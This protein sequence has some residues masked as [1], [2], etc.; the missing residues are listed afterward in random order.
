MIGYIILGLS[1]VSV[2]SFILIYNRFAKLRAEIDAAWSEIDI[3]LLRRH[4]LIPNLVEAVKAYMAHEK[5]TLTQ[6]I[7]ARGAAAGAKSVG[8]KMKAANGLTAALGRFMMV[9]ERYPD[10]KADKNVSELTEELTTTENRIAFSRTHY[11]NS[12]TQNNTLRGQFPSNVVA[13]LFNFPER[14][15]FAVDEAKKAAIQEAPSVKF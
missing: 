3:Q 5:E 13:N 15:F 9:M 7:E 12:V 11:N 10:L 14:E 6:V 1:A 8:D 4:D 2:V